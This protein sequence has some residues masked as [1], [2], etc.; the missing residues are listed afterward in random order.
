MVLIGGALALVAG[1]LVVFQVLVSGVLIFGLAYAI[2]KPR[3]LALTDRGLVLFSRRLGGKPSSV[4]GACH[5][6]V[7][8]TGAG[9]CSAASSR[10]SSAASGIGSGRRTCSGSWPRPG[11]RASPAP[12]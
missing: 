4:I 2:N 10:R 11:R 12:A 1:M 5:A 6:S 8:T 3:N 7:L 9:R